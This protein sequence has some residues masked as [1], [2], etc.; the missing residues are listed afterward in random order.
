MKN[1]TEIKE[2]EFD[3]VKFFR[4]VKEKIAKETKGMNFTEFKEYISKRKLKLA[5]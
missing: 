4:E 1:K 5:R 2:K 3:T